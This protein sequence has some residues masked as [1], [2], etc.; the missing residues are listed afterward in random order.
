[1]SSNTVCNFPPKKILIT[2]G[3]SPIALVL[4]RLFHLYGHTVMIAESMQSH[5][6]GFSNAVSKSFIV[7]SPRFNSALYMENMVKVAKEEKIDLIVPI[8]EEIFYLAKNVKLLPSHCRL[9]APP[10]DLLNQL[11]N[12]WLFTL[13]MQELGIETAKTYLIR[14]EKDLKEL[15]SGSFALKASYSRAALNLKRVMPHQPLPEITFEP[16]NPWIAQ[17][18][19]EGSQFCSYSICQEGVIQAHATYPV[20]HTAQGKGCIVFK[21]IDHSAVFMWIE[22]FVKAVNFTGQIAFDFI[23]SSEG[24]LFAIECNPR[25]THGIFLLDD[26]EKLSHAFFGATPSPI[27]PP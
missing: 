27:H 16:H 24:R 15:P 19:L 20:G 21:A 9:F 3:R 7:P 12:K 10:F 1:M 17:E 18:W 5:V 8:Y 26:Q 14:S 23:E 25:A 2:S 6:C 11:H 22:K 4:A 13:K